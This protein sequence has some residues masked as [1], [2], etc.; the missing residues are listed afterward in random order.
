MKPM[1]SNST[2]DNST[3]PKTRKGSSSPVRMKPN[4]GPRRPD[5][6]TRESLDEHWE[7]VQKADLSKVKVW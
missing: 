7:R 3:K 4:S 2:Q 5:Y 1:N 6:A